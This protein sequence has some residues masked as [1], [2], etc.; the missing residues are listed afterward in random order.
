MSWAHRRSRSGC[1]CTSAWSSPTS[2]ACRPS[3]RS[4]S[5]RSSIA[6]KRDSSSRVITGRAKAS[7][8]KSTRAAPRHSASASRSTVAAAS[9]SPAWR[10]RAAFC[11]EPVEAGRVERVARQI[12]RVA[13]SARRDPVLTEC[14]SQTRDVNLQVVARWDALAA[15]DV[16]EELVG[17]NRVPLRQREVDE[18]RAWT[19]AADVDGRTVVVEYFERPQ[20]SEL[21]VVHRR[22]RLSAT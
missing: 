12:Q 13:T 2:S 10:A 14:A 8:A 16:F 21:H 3:N 17:R 20:D 11:R 4:A 15:P 18:Q 22:P 1:S 7:S 19:R 5:T 6:V 9:A